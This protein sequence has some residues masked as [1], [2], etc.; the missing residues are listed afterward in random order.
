VDPADDVDEF[1]RVVPGAGEREGSN[2]PD[3]REDLAVG[4][5]VEDKVYST[6]VS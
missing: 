3:E 4:S 5:E 2:L 6:R 1:G